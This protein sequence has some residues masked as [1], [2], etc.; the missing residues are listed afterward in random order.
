MELIYLMKIK[1]GQLMNNDNQLLINFDFKK[2]Y[3][4]QDFYVTKSNSDAYTLI[5]N[6]PRWIKRTI[7]LYGEKYSGKTHLSKIFQE[8]TSCISIKSENFSNETL[9][10]FKTKQAI[11]IME[12]ATL[13]AQKHQFGLVIPCPNRGS[14]PGGG[15]VPRNTKNTNFTPKS[16][17]LVKFH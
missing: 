10:K 1:N 9:S 15:K 16:P 2:N 13:A 11:K 3:F 17:F 5:N 8:K 4:N 6:W 12:K 7:N 14:A